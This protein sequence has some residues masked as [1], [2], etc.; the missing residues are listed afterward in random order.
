MGAPLGQNPQPNTTQSGTLK[1]CPITQNQDDCEDVLTDGRL[2]ECQSKQ[3]RRFEIMVQG[4]IVEKSF[5]FF[6]GKLKDFSR[7]KDCF[8]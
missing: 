6:A 2:S 3:E 1:R 4:S 7:V 5:V 8:V